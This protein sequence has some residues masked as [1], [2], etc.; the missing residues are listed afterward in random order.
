MSHDRGFVAP[1]HLANSA[2]FGKMTW[3][4]RHP[5]VMESLTRQ[6]DL[7]QVG[8]TG[9]QAWSL[10]ILL[11]FAYLAEALGVY[12]VCLIARFGYADDYMELTYI[13]SGASASVWKDTVL[14]GRPFEG[15]WSISTFTL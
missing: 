3:R 1:G 4:V 10:S 11:L 9:Q 13:Q 5:A 8:K 12:S 7:A 14:N 15:L 6:K 2:T